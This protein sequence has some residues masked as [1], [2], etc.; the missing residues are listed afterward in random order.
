MSP[1]EP[2]HAA[3]ATRDTGRQTRS[4]LLDAASALFAQHGLH[5]VSIAEIAEK[6]DVFPSQVT[7]YFGSKEALF[8]EAA[9]REVLYA[10]SAVE[11]AAQG[12]R[13]PEQYVRSLVSTALAS[14][15][16]LTFAE[17]MLLARSRPDLAPLVARTFERLHREGERAVAEML[18]RR[19]WKL[20]T[21]PAIEARAF[22]ATVLGV[23]LERAASG[24]AFRR[25]TAE[26]A[27]L[28]VLNLHEMAMGP[29][30]SGERARSGR[31]G[32]AG[33]QRRQNAMNSPSD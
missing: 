4:A 22:W 20:R 9:C 16:L 33:P 2:R 1:R 17:A 23:A 15:A 12:A 28:L 30:R 8:V 6:A 13:T 11:A 24:E 31:R 7:Y 26:A 5:G 10:A 3:R 19:G 25:E 18:V 21:A 27:V 32:D 14:P 29:R